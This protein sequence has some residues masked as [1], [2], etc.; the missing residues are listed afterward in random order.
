MKC[1][2]STLE[3]LCVRLAGPPS[4]I[5]SRATCK[6]RLAF[7]LRF[8]CSLTNKLVPVPFPADSASRFQPPSLG[9]FNAP[10]SIASIGMAPGVILYLL[11]G[12]FAFFA[13]VLLWLCF[14]KLDSTRYP[15]KL[16]GDLGQRIFGTWARYLA[17]FLQI[18]QLT[19]NVG[20][21]VR[22]SFSRSFPFAPPD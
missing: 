1:R 14:L 15:I 2:S 7:Q 9:P 10:Y 3:G 16:Y 8:Y 17:G 4:S 13:G 11:F 18:I 21:I 5:S 6:T 19:L 22:F 20:L 12:V